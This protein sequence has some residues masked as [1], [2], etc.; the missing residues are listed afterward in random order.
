[1]KSRASI[2]LALLVVFSVGLAGPLHASERSW[3]QTEQLS[4]T[5]KESPATTSESG[6]GDTGETQGDPDG[7]LGGQ[8]LRPTPPI[9]TSM[10][11]ESPESRET[12]SFESLFTW[13]LM[14]IGLR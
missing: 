14:F 9:T 13:F 6:P 4:I 5:G 3:V 2:I 8:N 7:W 11:L 12:I 10:G 1:M